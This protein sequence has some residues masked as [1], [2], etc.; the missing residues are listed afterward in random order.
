M[1]RALPKSV[2]S[3]DFRVVQGDREVGVIEH[4]T[5]RERAVFQVKDVAFPM[6]REGLL[7]DF[8]LLFGEDVLA[9]ASKPSALGRRFVL[10]FE[11]RTFDLA[12]EHAFARRFVLR[13][14]EAVLGRIAPEGAFTRKTRVD[15]PEALPLP[16]QAFALWLVL[17]M[18]RRAQQSS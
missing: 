4:A 10:A 9:R 17:L 16:V 8:V 12:P 3:W 2:F 5:F 13:E 1:L 15:L 11:G 18:W 7:G 6:R 14:G